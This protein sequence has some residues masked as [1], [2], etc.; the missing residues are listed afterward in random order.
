MR[1]I[2]LTADRKVNGVM[3]ARGAVVSVDEATALML[4]GCGAALPA[5][6]AAKDAAP[7]NRARPVAQKRG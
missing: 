7:D 4:I 1:E 2:V 3:T 6:D 5:P